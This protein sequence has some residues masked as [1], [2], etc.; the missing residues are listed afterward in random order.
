MKNGKI[1]LVGNPN[2]G[3]TTLF[4]VLTGSSQHVGNWPGVTVEKKEGKFTYESNEY[5]VV[6]LPGIYSL[7]AFSDDE[8]VARDFILTGDADVIINVVDAGN[9]ERNLYLT[10]QLLEMEKKII[11]ALNMIDEAEKRS[12]KFDIQEL[13]KKLGVPVIPTIAYKGTGI[14]DIKEAAVNAIKNGDSTDNP[15]QY[16]G[17][18]GHH[19]NHMVEILDGKTLPYPI[20]W[21]AIKIVEGD[22]EIVKRLRESRVDDSIIDGINEFYKYHSS[23]SF[24]LEIVDSRYAF[25]HKAIEKAVIRP[26]K[27]VITV[28]DKIDKILTSK[29]LGIPAFAVIMLIV[30]QLTFVIGEDFLGELAADSIGWLGGHIETLLV[31]VNSPKWL[32]AF[33][34]NGAINGVGAII[35]F[36]PLI[37]VLYLLLGFL[38]DSGYMARAA[39]VWDD[40][41]RRFGLQ[42][43]AFISMIIGFG[44]NVP[45]IMSARTMDSKKDRMITMLINPFMSCGAKLPIYSVFIAAFFSKYGGLVLFLIYTLG[46]VVALLMAKLFNKTLFKG[47]SS[48]FIMELPPYR[49]PTAKNVLR[50]M[51][52]NV[53]EF[54][55][56]AGTIIFLVITVMWLLAVLPVSAE[57]YSQFS[58]LGRI[59]TILAPVFAHAGFGTWQEAVALFAGIP[60]KEAVVGTLGML[61]AGQYV[62]EGAILVDAIKLHFTHLTALSYMVMVL[63]YTPCVATLS[64]VAKETKSIKWS[65]V[66]AS[67]TFV[68]GWVAAVAVYQIGKLFGFN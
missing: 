37:T 38:E 68:I 24:E 27:D 53:S 39:Y 18:V 29:F 66:M 47:E 15:L 45:G 5:D 61:Y 31:L 49:M 6:D 8:V 28:T 11:V 32:I 59:G 60:A 22:S 63:L 56:K 10:V 13:S 42:G 17:T 55:K 40:L 35:E 46:I 9:I 7:G 57:P 16:T 33:V 36:V 19:V 3:K 25:S 14:E 26:D 44:C 48:Y 65:L 43:R 30:F 58:I 64:I 2:S 54:V 20:K 67:Y 41:M 34:V 1:A 12:I 23:D 21:T 4:N 52:D 51:W 62:E 50:N